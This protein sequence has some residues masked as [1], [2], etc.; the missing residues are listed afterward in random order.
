MPEF[1]FSAKPP[2]DTQILLGFVR[3]DVGSEACRNAGVFFC[4]A[5][6]RDDAAP[7]GA[8]APTDFCFDPFRSDL[9]VAYAQ[10][11]SAAWMAEIKEVRLVTAAER[12]TELGSS[13][14]SMKAAYYYRFQ[15]QNIQA[16]A[17]RDV[18]GLVQRRP[19]KPIA[20]TLT[21]FAACPLAADPQL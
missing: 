20:R 5:V 8:G 12:A 10:N 9:F 17:Y 7:G 18:S 19:G 21:E 3:D 14:S 2:Q 15:L 4:H 1:Q 11:R 6:E 13:E 16:V